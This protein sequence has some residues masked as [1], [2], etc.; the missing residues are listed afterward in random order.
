MPAGDDRGLDPGEQALAAWARALAR[1]PNA[2]T[3]ADVEPLRAAGYDDAEILA[4]T[5]FVTLRLSFSTVNDA[6][7]V[8]PDEQLRTV[9]PAPVL[10]AVT[11]GRPIAG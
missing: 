7:G 2:T 6:L 11:F 4:L 10:D 3:A 8:H 9:A 1:D 5:M